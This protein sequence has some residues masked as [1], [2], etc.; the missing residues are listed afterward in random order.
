MITLL[1][2]VTVNAT[3]RLQVEN[4][5]DKYATYQLKKSHLNDYPTENLYQNIFAS[6]FEQLAIIFLFRIYL[7]DTIIIGDNSP[8]PPLDGPSLR[9]ASNSKHSYEC[10]CGSCTIMELKFI[11]GVK[12]KNFKKKFIHNTE[13]ER[14]RERVLLS[15]W[16]GSTSSTNVW[17]ER[18]RERKYY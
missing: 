8:P 4:R 14:E 16:L 3:M 7:K 12:L 10:Y 15:V 6:H 9:Q 18:E 11:L 1:S 2:L 5:L 13:R 17:H